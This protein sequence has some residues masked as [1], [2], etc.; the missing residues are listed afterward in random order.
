MLWQ[1]LFIIARGPSVGCDINQEAGLACM[2]R[3]QLDCPN[4]IA[5]N[6]PLGGDK[7]RSVCQSVS[8]ILSAWS[9]R[10][11]TAVQGDHHLSGAAV[12]DDL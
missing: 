10:C 5:G 12:A 8:R 11:E 1:R 9:R 4:R 3:S 2:Q 7:T 6:K